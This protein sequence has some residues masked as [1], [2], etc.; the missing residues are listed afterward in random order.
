M[1]E[2]DGNQSMQAYCSCYFIMGLLLIVCCMFVHIFCMQFL[3][4]TLMASNSANVIIA[5]VVLSCCILDEKFITKYDLPAIIF[6]SL[7]CVTL[8]LNANFE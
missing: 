1:V 6:I 8:V 2:K 5:A 3:D 7:G 4:L